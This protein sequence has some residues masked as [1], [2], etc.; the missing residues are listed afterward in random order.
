MAFQPEIE[1]ERLLKEKRERQARESFR[2][3]ARENLRGA[4][5]HASTQN[6]LLRERDKQIK[7]SLGNAVTKYD[8]PQGT[9]TKGL[10]DLTFGN[11]KGKLSET[12]TPED[13]RLFARNAAAAQERFAGG[14]TPQQVIDL[15]RDIDRERSN[16]QIFLA[17]PFSHKEET[18]R[19]VTNAGP[20]SKD[21]RHYVTVQFLGYSG[22]LT[23][24]RDKNV[25]TV[26]KYIA[27]GKIR[28]T[29]DCGRHRYY[30][31][32]IAGLGN[33]HLGQREARFPF[34]RNPSL[35]GVACKHV[36]RVMQVITSPLGLDYVLRQAQKDRAKADTLPANRTPKKSELQAELDR[37]LKQADGK[38]QQITPTTERAGHKRKMQNAAIKA[39][40]E[41]AVKQTQETARRE[42]VGRLQ[43]A[44]NAGLITQ[45]DFDLLSKV[46]A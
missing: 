20:D 30:Y 23:G 6:T 44:L 15:S 17:A 34:I 45:Q 43:A 31:N 14:I 46:T 26:R 42:R 41:Q 8:V 25:A 12:L 2:K 35:G 33:Y 13:I 32:Y 10:L 5:N 24:A 9:D 7:E 19:Y 37:Q 38:R 4:T 11:D 40:K 29:C 28:F 18:F 22:L 36:L 3:Q 39:A 1:R 16:K 21:T 27:A